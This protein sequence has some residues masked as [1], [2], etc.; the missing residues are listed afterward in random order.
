[1][2]ISVGRVAV[3]HVSPSQPVFNEGIGVGLT[4]HTVAYVRCLLS[5]VDD[6]S[7]AKGRTGDEVGT[8]DHCFD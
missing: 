7:F 5:T 3:L 2:M 8:G 1:M 6:L 4:V